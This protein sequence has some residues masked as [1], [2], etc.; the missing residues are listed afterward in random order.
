MAVTEG[1]L[2]TAIEGYITAEYGSPEEAAKLT[3]FATA[4]AKSFIYFQ[5]NTDVVVPGITPGGSTASG[6]IE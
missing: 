6:T 5:S 4:L 3:K 2:I 1:D